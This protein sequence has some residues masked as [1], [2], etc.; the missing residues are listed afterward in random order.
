MTVRVLRIALLAAALAAPGCGGGK[1]AGGGGAAAPAQLVIGVSSD[2]DHLNPLVAG[3]AF[4][5]DLCDMLFLR[6]AHWGPPPAYDFVP[7]LAESWDLSADGLALTYHLRHDVTWSDGVPTTAADVVFTFER[8]RDPKVPFANRSRLRLIESCTAPDEWTVVFRFSERS[9]EPVFTTGFPVVPEHLLKDVPPEQ[10]DSCAFDRAPVGNGP[11]TLHEWVRAERVVFAANDACALG[12]PVYDRVVFRIIPEE[13]TL[14]TELL[15]GGVDV[16]D[17][18]PNKWY[19]EDSQR[20]DLR[21]TRMSDKGY[22]YIGWNQKNPRFQD[23]RVRRA[24][25]LATDRQG[26]LTAFRGGFGEVSAQPLFAGHPDYD[27]DLKPLPFDPDSAARLLDEAGWTGRDPDG[28]RT[29]DG[30]RLEFT[31]MLIAANEI[32]EEISTMTQAEYR[33]LGIGVTSESYEWTVYIQRLREKRFDAT[34][35]ARRGDLL[36]DPEDVFH[37]RAIVGQYNDISFGNA[38]TDSLIDLAKSTPDRT[39]RRRIWWR[40]LEE[41]DRLQPVTILY[42]SETSYPVRRDRVAKDPMDLRGPYFQLRD[43]EPVAR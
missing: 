40:F 1:D 26:I 27:P 21:F 31:Y 10:M 23:P 38:V 30:T 35:L 22:V 34:I 41:L 17:R 32:S 37:S 28:V 11:W 19:R 14:R 24:L 39:V 2:P 33:K 3:T 16:Y 13:T 7:V 6:L 36:F 5:V 9:W 43:W 8:A 25:T 20:P 4:G 29:R 12:R 15:T 42:V 18:H